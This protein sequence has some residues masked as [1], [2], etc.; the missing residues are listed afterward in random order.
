[1]WWYLSG[2]QGD[3]DAVKAIDAIKVKM[4]PAQIVQAKKLASQWKPKK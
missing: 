4:S 3:R 2:S 1:M